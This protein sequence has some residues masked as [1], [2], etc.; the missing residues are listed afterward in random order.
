MELRLRADDEARW[1]NVKCVAVRMLEAGIPLE[2][3]E[4]YL[5]ACSKRIASRYYFAGNRWGWLRYPE[6]TDP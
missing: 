1:K 5:D 3:I 6:P 4:I 2:E